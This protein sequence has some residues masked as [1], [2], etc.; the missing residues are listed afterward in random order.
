MVQKGSKLRNALDRYQ[1]KYH[2]LEQQKKHQKLAEKKKTRRKGQGAEAVLSNPGDVN[3]EDDAIGINSVAQ[4]GR[5]EEFGAGAVDEPEWADEEVQ[6]GWETDEA[7]ENGEQD[8]DEEERRTAGVCLSY[9]VR[10][11][12]IHSVAHEGADGDNTTR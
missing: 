9:C 2:R 7:S 5:A 8:V 11:N 12:A 3:G 1:G 10:G 4:E 6:D